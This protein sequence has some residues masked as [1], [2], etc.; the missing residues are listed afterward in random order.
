MGCATCDQLLKREAEA[1]D[2][3]DH[4][5]AIDALVDLEQHQRELH[6]SGATP[7]CTGGS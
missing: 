4:S 6:G 3:D 7:L 2:K 5:E 1:Q